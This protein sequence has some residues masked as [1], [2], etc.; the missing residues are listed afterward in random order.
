MQPWMYYLLFCVIAAV[1]ILRDAAD[2]EDNDER[3][4]E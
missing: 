4:G 3:E 2:A 1:L